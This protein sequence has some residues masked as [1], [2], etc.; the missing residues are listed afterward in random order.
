MIDDEGGNDYIVRAIVTL[1]RNLGLRVIAEGIETEAQ[2]EKLKLLECEGGQGYYFAEP[3]AYEQLREF[4][5][6][7]NNIDLP[8]NRFDEV[9]TLQLIQ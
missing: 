7:G 8:N 4:I 2:L 5:F 9:P 3:M 1:A 6:D